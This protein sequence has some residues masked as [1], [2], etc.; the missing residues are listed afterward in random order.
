MKKQTYLSI[1][2]IVAVLMIVFALTIL[3]DALSQANA[4]LPTLMP[5]LGAS[6]V[7][8]S[9]TQEATATYAPTDIISASS[10]AKDSEL[11]DVVVD[12]S[13]VEVKTEIPPTPT[14]APAS[15]IVSATPTIV[16]TPRSTPAVVSLPP[17]QPVPNVVI[18]RVESSQLSQ[19]QSDVV[20]QG[21]TIQI[22][23]ARL[24]AVTVS[25]PDETAIEQIVQAEY[26]QAS[27]PDYFVSAQATAIDPLMNQQWS[28]RAMNIPVD[29]PDDLPEV[30]VAIIDSG[31]CQHFELSGKVLQGYDFVDGDA[32]PQDE[33]GHG[34]AVA[35][36]VA[37]NWDGQGIAGIAPNARLLVYR[38]LNAQGSGRYSHVASAIVRAVDEGA[39]IINMSLGGVNSSQLL[40]DAVNYASSK[41][42]ML[43]AAAGNNGID[44][45]LYPAAYANVVSVGAFDS[46]GLRAPF[47]N[48]G[49]VDIWAPGVDVLSLTLADD[50]NV[51]SGTS[52]AAPNVTGL[53]ALELAHGRRL[54]VGGSAR[55]EGA[56]NV[57]VILQTPTAEP[58]IQ[59]L[60]PDNLLDISNWMDNSRIDTEQIRAGYV[61]IGD[62]LVPEEALHVDALGNYHV[63]PS[64]T[65]PTWIDGIVPYQFAP[66]LTDQQRNIILEAMSWWQNV[67]PI[68]FVPRTSQND[69][70]YIFRGIGNWSYVGRTTGRQELSI[71][72]WITWIAAHELGH[73]L[74]LWH[75]HQRTDRDQY[76]DIIVDNII[77]DTI[78]NFNKIGIA[79][80][81]YDFESIMH[82]SDLAFSRNGQPTIV[83]KPG[84]EQFQSVMGNRFNL[85]NGDGRVVRYLYTPLA[86]INNNIISNSNF[87]QGFNRWSTYEQI[88]WAIYNDVLY[89]KRP[90]GVADSA[91][92]QNIPW[93][94]TNGSGLELSFDIGNASSISKD[95]IV[96]LRSVDT[97]E[98]AVQCSFTVP[99][100]T[101]LRRYVITGSSREWIGMVVE[102][103]VNA[104]GIPNAMLDNVSLMRKTSL[105]NTPTNCSWA[106]A[107][108][109]VNLVSNSTFDT[110]HGWSQ[111]G[112]LTF[113]IADGYA[114]FVSKPTSVAGLLMD[115]FYSL[116]VN[117][118]VEMTF[119]IRNTGTESRNIRAAIN[120]QVDWSGSVYCDFT[121]PPT[122][123]YL[124][125]TMRGRVTDV[126]AMLRTRI[127]VTDSSTS[128]A[129]LIDDVF[130][131]YRPALSI[132][133]T[134]CIL[135][136]F[137]TPAA[138]VLTAP[139][140]TLTNNNRPTVAWN[141]V[142][143]ATSYIVEFSN[144][145]FASVIH[146]QT[147]TTTSYT[148]VDALPDGT[149]SIRVRGVNVV[150]QAG[151]NSAVKSLTVD[152]I[153]PNP[154]VL[155]LPL[156]N[157]SV[158]TFTPT[159]SWIA[160]GTVGYELQYGLTNPPTQVIGNLTTTSYTFAQPQNV[161]T[162]YWQV[163]ARDAAG[164]WSAWSDIRLFTIN[165]P[166]G[167]APRVIQHNGNTVTLTWLPRAWAQ[168]SQ[169]EIFTNSGLTM[170]YG[171]P[172][173]VEAGIWELTTS[174]PSG[175]Y[176]WRVRLKMNATTWG[177]WSPVESIIVR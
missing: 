139:T 74:G 36:I 79:Y 69:Y 118:P 56:E 159:L 46:E 155:H 16:L 120:R 3:R 172:I 106:L 86:P 177:A 171:Q 116:P 72:S 108:A 84:Y 25:L 92:I 97:W 95:F 65:T 160:S 23:D 156:M 99:P 10:Q 143:N 103:R 175:T 34:C 133:T 62:M 40:Q 124:T 157:A 174:L 134:Q 63:N 68:T 19:L 137:A 35:G 100:Q 144:N 47:S 71:E 48:Y 33:M 113:N 18:L 122:P 148:L 154:P 66:D 165:N 169:I 57:A 129:I 127:D 43:I 94:V 64:Y 115:M 60:N 153:P 112:G 6:L 31:I 12:D 45:A 80:G 58:T 110:P 138:P 8:I 76:I 91:I 119:K 13:I 14:Q 41:G 44:S 173:E 151:A 128:P 37:A 49:K 9:Q 42:V 39:Q 61:L 132:T 117:S 30:R 81:P 17:A 164:N 140:V 83:A 126:M 24:G 104:D 67:A 168:G 28:L 29:L 2:T 27:E 152:T 142:A 161:G 82:Y 109:N 54:S 87:S 20:A 51:F 90:T 88:D 167:S 150:G 89:F 158:T 131:Y 93:R 111:S 22:V 55:Y 98:H 162:L 176:F 73:A 107:P 1:A 38:V 125:Y 96:S 101:P 77:S 123:T 136:S 21:G 59:M 130:V 147:V 102:F 50:Y 166:A 52:F 141:S 53:A 70:I 26:V 114:T 146:T 11:L 149:Y 145:N 75:E 135:P 85:S 7:E 78:H 15:V 163:R 5:T 105:N 32:N 4:P 170:R 121:V